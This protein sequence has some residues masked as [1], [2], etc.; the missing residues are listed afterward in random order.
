MISARKGM[1]MGGCLLVAGLLLAAPSDKAAVQITKDP[2]GYWFTE[3]DTKVLF[4][5]LERKALPDGRAERSNYFHP[6]Y[7]LD[8]NVLTQDFPPDHI[9]HRGIYWAWHQVL[10]DGKRIQDQW[11]NLD[12]F[13]PVQKAEVVSGANSASLKLR[14]FWE[15]PKVADDQGKRKPFVEENSVTRVHKAEGD[16]R[17]IDF[18]QQLSA[19][20]DG[21]EI[22]GSEDAKGYGG[23]SYRIAMPEDIRFIGDK[24]VVTPTVNAV[25]ASPWMDVAATYGP[26]GKSGIAV[27]THPTTT[28]FPQTW[29]LRAK[30][31]MQN[32]VYPG[33]HPVALAKGKPVTLRYRL[34]LHR[35]ELPPARIK[36][37][38]AE[39]AKESP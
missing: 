10:L 13:W 14:V 1:L 36:Q 28:G 7:D 4:Y 21:V 6:L 22:G 20:V 3:G 19:L 30:G 15:S 32:A 17:K 29:I 9:H 24:G 34:V 18:H 35:G 16:I 11:S 2:Q 33:Q 39:Y 27:L 31:S 5:Q 37:L 23:F 26:S 25:D 12:S 8:G 38:Q